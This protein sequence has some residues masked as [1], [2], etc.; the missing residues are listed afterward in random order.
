MEDLFN[1]NNLLPATPPVAP[2][3]ES[4]KPAEQVAVPAAVVVESKSVQ[5][6][7]QLLEP[8]QAPVQ[9]SEPANSPEPVAMPEPPPPSR[10]FLAIKIGILSGA[11]FTIALGALVLFVYKQPTS[12]QGQVVQCTT[13][14]HAAADQNAAPN[15]SQEIKECGANQY[16]VNNGPDFENGCQDIHTFNLL[17][18]NGQCN[19]INQI[20]QSPETYRLN[21]ETKKSLADWYKTCNANVALS[22]GANQVADS[23]GQC[24]CQNNYKVDTTQKVGLTQS[25]S[26]EQTTGPANLNPTQKVC[27]YDCESTITQIKDLQA[28]PTTPELALQLQQLQSDAQA[29]KCALPELSDDQKI[30]NQYQSDAGTAL[31]AEK[32]IDYFSASKK[33]IEANCSGKDG[34]QCQQ[35]L[36]EVNILNDLINKTQ[37]PSQKTVLKA[38]R[39]KLKDNYYSDPTC[40]QIQTRCQELEPIYGLNGSGAGDQTGAVP[41]ATDQ[42]GATQQT[43]S[44]QS[45]ITFPELTP[46]KIFNDD[47]DYYNQYCGC[48][49]LITKYADVN[50]ATSDIT[51]SEKAKLETCKKIKQG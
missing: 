39:A 50:L 10:T 24:V 38:Q 21:A 29:N 40:N 45:Q 41:A 19:I 47:K 4:T 12:L 27:I 43:E 37:D 30:C 34:N 2:E 5:T 20:Y 17:P 25:T 7:G 22:C 1:P 3:N 33:Y 31:A 42:T 18:G 14:D 16:F 51:D 46:A 9:S 48:D 36:A 13:G 6:M 8:A 28:L 44:Q 15:Q 26:S 35:K 32:F 23:N 11:I 49:Q